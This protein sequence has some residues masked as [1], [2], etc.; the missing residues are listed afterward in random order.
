MQFLYLHLRLSNFWMDQPQLVLKNS[1]KQ[2]SLQYLA[3]TGPDISFVVNQLSQFIN[4]PTQTSLIASKK[5]LRYLKGTLFHGLVLNK[6]SNLTITASQTL[7]NR[8]FR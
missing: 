2:F 8:K 1:E 5:V 7:I 6:E 4:M 3:L